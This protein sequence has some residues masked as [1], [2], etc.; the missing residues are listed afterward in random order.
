MIA[1]FIF[2]LH[3][4]L[5]RMQVPGVTHEELRTL[6]EEI[7]KLMRE[8]LEDYET[9]Q[10]VIGMNHVFRG[11]S[12]KAW[13]GTKFRVNEH[14]GWNTIVNQHCLNHYCKCWKYRND[15]LHD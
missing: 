3:E 9:N 12:I 5:K 13:K 10:Q 7:L 6:I 4:D 11:F 8:D 15:E 1:E 14:I 2:Q